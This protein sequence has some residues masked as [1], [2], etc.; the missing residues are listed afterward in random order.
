[1]IDLNDVKYVINKRKIAYECDMMYGDDVVSRCQI[2]VQNDVWTIAEWFT[3][4]KY[5]HHG[6][7]TVLL[8]HLLGEIR[9]ECELPGGF[10]YIWN[11]TNQYVYDWLNENFGALSKCPIAVLKVA[12]D[13]DW[14]SHVYMLNREKFITYFNLD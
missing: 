13:D 3:T 8:K 12:N 14:L 6:Y 2:N 7:G 1:M 5:Q 4:A 10:E 9:K 11:G